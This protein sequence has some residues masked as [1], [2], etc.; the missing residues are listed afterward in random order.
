MFVN[1]SISCLIRGIAISLQSDIR[2]VLVN[3]QTSRRHCEI[4]SKLCSPIVR[5]WDLVAFGDQT[6]SDS[7]LTYVD[8]EPRTAL[9]PLRSATGFDNCHSQNRFVSCLVKAPLL[10]ILRFSDVR[11]Y[12]DEQRYSHEQRCSDEQRYSHGQRYS[13]GQQTA[14]Q[15]MNPSQHYERERSSLR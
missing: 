5:L 11:P 2:K 1:R 13:C 3:A 8:S 15:G 9:A 4:C 7:Y 12:S 10:E 14:I 6:N